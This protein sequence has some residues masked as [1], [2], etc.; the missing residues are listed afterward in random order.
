MDGFQGF[1]ILRTGIHIAH[2]DRDRRAQGLA[3][4]HAAQNLGVVWL[5]PARPS[6]QPSR[7][8]PLEGILKGVKI[9]RK[10]SGQAIDDRA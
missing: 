10:P 1:I 9:H 2:D 4:K 7:A 6:W 8:P 3:L 5:L